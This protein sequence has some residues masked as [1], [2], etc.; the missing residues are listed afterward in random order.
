MFED[1]VP[2]RWGR[3]VQQRVRSGFASDIAYL[4]GVSDFMRMGA[5]RLS[6]ASRPDVYLADN[7]NVPK[8]IHIR[9]LEEACGRLE[10]GL[11]TED[12]LRHL[13]G[14][15]SLL[16]GARP[17]AGVQDTAVN[18]RQIQTDKVNRMCSSHFCT[19]IESAIG[20]VERSWLP[21]GAHSGY[22]ACVCNRGLSP[23]PSSMKAE[24]YPM[25][26]DSRRSTEPAHFLAATY[27]ARRY[28]ASR[29]KGH[30]RP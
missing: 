26:S 13:F 21:D 27:T 20:K 14:P 4:L 18:V 5:L 6:D 29:Q 19:S 16:G 28:R 1:I 15:G 22:H 2:D 12:D 10:N 17:K 7:H 3:M 11:E 8:L 25:V 9:E 23:G 24:F 30:E